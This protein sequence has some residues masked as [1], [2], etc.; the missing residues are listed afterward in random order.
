MILSAFY[1]AK[2]RIFL[3]AVILLAVAALF[4]IRIFLAQKAYFKAWFASAT[5]IVACTF[6]GVIGLF[7]RMFPSNIDAD[8]SLTA[9]NASSSPLT[10][11]IVL[12]VVILFVPLV[13]AYQIW[14]GM[15]KHKSWRQNIIS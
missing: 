10:L 12:V 11:K 7:P 1:Q 9:H 4:A 5:T 2:F 6:Y 3:F 14:A 13:L 15:K 8:Y